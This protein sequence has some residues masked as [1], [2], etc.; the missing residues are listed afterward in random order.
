[1]IKQFVLSA[2]LLTSALS[3]TACAQEFP[4]EV[5]QGPVFGT[6]SEMKSA[7]D[8]VIVYHNGEEPSKKNWGAM[9]VYRLTLDGS[10]YLVHWSQTEKFNKLKK[11]DKV[12]LHPSG[13]FMAF[14]EKE[15]KPQ[16]FPLMNIYKSDHRIN[17]VSGM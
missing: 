8:K 12:N 14:G 15:M 9:T 17:P 2:F 4:K 5:S 16:V 3:L 11:G 1:M 6:V 10:E 7:D 13:E